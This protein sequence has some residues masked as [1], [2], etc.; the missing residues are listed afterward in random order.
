M[1]DECLIL[2]IFNGGSFDR[3]GR[4][5]I[6]AVKTDSMQA[7]FSGQISMVITTAAVLR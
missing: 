7:I 4:P 3:A 6:E 1:T 2:P 5:D